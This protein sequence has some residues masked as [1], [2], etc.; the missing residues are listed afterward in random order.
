LIIFEKRLT[1]PTDDQIKD[2]REG[3][4]IGFLHIPKE[5]SGKPILV[6]AH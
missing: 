3:R 5:H 6:S 4:Q 1:D 2:P